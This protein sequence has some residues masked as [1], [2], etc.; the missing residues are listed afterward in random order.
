MKKSET[1]NKDRSE[2]VVAYLAVIM[3][4]S[5]GF[6]FARDV[7]L[8]DIYGATSIADIYITTLSIPEVIMDLLAQTITLG[9]IPITVGFLLSDEGRIN[10]FTSSVLKLLLSV[11]IVFVLL[12]LLFPTGVIHVLA[13]GFTEGTGELAKEFLR[14]ISLSILFRTVANILNAFLNANKCFVPG[15]FFG[16][17]LDVCIISSIYLS[18]WSGQLLWL[19]IGAVIGTVCQMVFLIPFAAKNQLSLDVKAPFICKETKQLVVM[20]VPAAM[21]IGVLQITAMVNKALASSLVD[22]GITMLNYSNK[23]SYFTENIIVSSVAT[24]IYPLLSE[25]SIQNRLDLF[26]NELKNAINKLI[27]FLVP[28]ACGLACISYEIIDFLFGHGA[29]TDDAV[30]Q[31][32]ELMVLSVIGI[33]GIGIQTLLTRAIFSLKRI[34]TSILTSLSL[35]IS[36]V[37]LSVILSKLWGLKGIAIATGL[38]YNLGGIVYYIIINKICG[39]IGI[40]N[41][42]TVLIKSLVSSAVMVS[43][44][45]LANRSLNIQGITYIV[46]S[47]CLGVVV[48]F[49]MCNVLHVEEAS[50]SS[51]K[52][53]LIRSK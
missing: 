32:A 23:I 22:G 11:G 16:L 14:I 51:I 19:P 49:V 10:Q 48:Y 45:I 26:A 40:K 47:I 18:K 39:D 3:L 8:A 36:F 12:F 17:I 13:P 5:K 43:L 21:A 29:F 31:T 52:K 44:I 35:L 25:Y 20:I 4:L 28:A 34:K 24:V 1:Y 6:G 53:M 38:S 9:Y 33:C 46:V 27:V 30:Q 41:N 50:I 42:I 37:S 15:A 7:I 2:R